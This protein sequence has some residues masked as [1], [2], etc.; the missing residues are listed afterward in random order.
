MQ[1]TIRV[2]RIALPIVFV[3]FIG[4]LIAN[5]DSSKN[6]RHNTSSEAVTSTQRPNEKPRAEAW[7]FRDVQTIGGRV[8]SEIVATRVV[9]FESGWTTLEG[10]TLTLYRA[11]G[12]TY[13]VSCPQAQFNSQT[14]EADAKGGVRVTSSDGIEIATAQIRYDGARLTNDIP[15]QF[16][17]DRW[18]GNAGALDLDV[19]GETLE[20]SKDVNA[21][22]I[23][24]QPTDVPMN[25]RG[26]ETT[27]RRRENTIEFRDRVAMSRGADN[28]HANFMLGKFTQDR[29]QLISLEGTGNAMIVMA[30]NPT[31]GEDLGG[32]KTITCDGF[33]TEL[34]PDGQINAFV[35]RAAEHPAHAVLDGPPK[36][37]ILARGF[38]V[39]IANRVVTDIRADFEVVMKELGDAP[40]QINTDHATV[41]FDPATRRARSAFLD[42]AFRYADPKNTAS[43][44][45]ANYDIAGDKIVLTTDVGWQATVVSDGQVLKAKVIEFSPRAQTAHASGSVIAQLAS[46]GKGGGAAASADATSLFPAG[47]PVFVNADDLVLR[48]VNKV[49]VFTGNVRA[50]QD[51]NTLLASELQMQGAGEIV[52]ARGNV[53]T[54]LYNTTAEARKTPVKSESEQLIARK[55][56]KR[57]DLVGKVTIVDETR[58]L[59]SEKSTFF[60]DDK[61]KIQRIE[62]EQNVNVAETANGRKGTGDKAIYQVEKKM[63]YVFGTPATISDP[64]G[65]VAGQQIVFD[66]TKNRVQ[67]VSPEGQTKGT[68][69]HEGP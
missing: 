12:L 25:I 19:Q 56:E 24:S 33:N 53:R 27:F 46:K 35:A 38:R 17:V 42:G 7:A 67:V 68:Y 43:A 30:A 61:N 8:A 65:S 14:K 62:A 13:V 15:V 50:W 36:R 55:I 37:D 66:L 69:K 18:N 45:R 1:R 60:F 59:K 34:G 11:N 63:I 51:N 3:A 39:G 31:P 20:L 58:T 5:W 44:F 22:M 52:T 48:Q 9:S 28:V 21:T 40:R 23:A 49:A 4:V 26:R 32:R 47:K 6:K 16:R 54:M 2:L 41:W 57:I 64:T 29:K 10:V